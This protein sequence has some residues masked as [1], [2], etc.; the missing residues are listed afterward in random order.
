MSFSRRSRAR[1]AS[2]SDTTGAGGLGPIFLYRNKGENNMPQS[3]SRPVLAS[4]LLLLVLWAVAGLGCQWTSGEEFLSSFKN[5]KMLKQGDPVT[6]NGFAIG[7]VTAIRPSADGRIEVTAKIHKDYLP[8]THQ[9]S[10]VFIAEESNGQRRLELHPLDISSPPIAKGCRLEGTETQVELQLLKAKAKIKPAIEDAAKQ[11]R[12][13]VRSVQDYLRS[14]EAQKLSDDTRE[15]LSNL[16][17]WADDEV[18]DFRA[19]HPDFETNLKQQIEKARKQGNE[20]L[21][22]LLQDLE[23]RLR[24]ASPEQPQPSH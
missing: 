18:Q 1:V 16:K 11:I 15:F 9:T 3:V 20:S 19:K 14:P 8:Q 24:D 12:S 4:P 6:Q 21:L 13:A 23:N 5:A 7:E 22:R 10:L 17:Q 2:E